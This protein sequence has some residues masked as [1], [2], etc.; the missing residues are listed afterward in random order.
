[1]DPDP[2]C[3]EGIFDCYDRNYTTCI[4]TGSSYSCQ[5]CLEGLIEVGDVCIG[6]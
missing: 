4:G 6:K 1:M 2:A 5:D 3:A